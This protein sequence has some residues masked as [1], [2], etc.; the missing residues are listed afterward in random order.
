MTR[1]LDTTKRS[2]EAKLLL[3]TFKRKI[4]G[5]E[6]ATHAL[7]NI[8]ESYQAGFAD[9][10]KPAGNALFLGPTGT[11]KTATVLALASGLFGDEKACLK[12]DCAEYQHGHE[13]AKLVGSPPGYLGH[14]ETHPMITQER[15]SK[16][17]TEKIK[18]SIVLFDEIEKSSDTLW[19]LLLGI[20]DKATLSLGDNRVVDFSQTIVI[21]TSNLGSTQM[22]ALVD[23]GI[24]F[25][26]LEPESHVTNAQMDDIATQAAKKKFTPEF[27]NRI[28]HVSVFHTLTREQIE[29]ILDIE[30]GNLQTRLL[31]NSRTKFFFHLLESAKKR[32]LKEGYDK[33]YGARHLKRTLER[34]VQTPLARI[35]ASG[36]IIDRDVIIIE[37][38]GGKELEF[39]IEEAQWQTK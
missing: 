30:T 27:F 23:G 25:Q 2:L 3:E 5:Q 36:Q 8:V 13:I 9:P 35:V 16:Y 21:M 4:V 18:L 26:T 31:F 1:V 19:N 12:I 33:V 37:D 17:H 11:G 10:G 32:I 15:L 7:L 34:L 22:S 6:D 20:L 39:S 28:E 29:H 24:G 14:R 38:T